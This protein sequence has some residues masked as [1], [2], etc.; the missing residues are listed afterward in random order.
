MLHGGEIYDKK[1]EL[2][3]SVSLNPLPCPVQVLDEI[4][5]AA[6]QVSN[7]PDIMQSEFVTAV[8]KAENRLSQKNAKFTAENIV[9]GNGAS[10]LLM[11]IVNMVRPKKALLPIPSFYGYE[12]ALGAAKDCATGHFLLREADGFVLNEDFIDA[13]TDDVDLVIL[14]NPNNPTGR[15]IP[16]SILVKTMD[17][18]RAVGATLIVD[19][20]FFRLSGKRDC[21]EIPQSA[22]NFTCEYPN[23]FV[24]DAYTK[25]FSIPGVRVGFAITSAENTGRLRRFLPEWNMSVFADRVGIKCAEI[26]GEGSF[27]KES[28]EMI[29]REKAYLVN[30]L[31]KIG[32]STCESDTNFILIRSDEELYNRLLEHK[33]LIRDCRTFDGLDI[34]YYRIAIKDHNANERLITAIK[35]L[36]NIRER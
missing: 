18:C 10:E 34:G 17:K 16:E 1:I 14:G 19:E 8:A 7:Y 15:L 2:D 35:T 23:L 20:C 28:L 33:I 25:L 24:V 12:H 5:T 30:E 26:T 31:E 9:G 3:F 11:A 21:E 32:I 29:Q 4:K 27:T 13:I 22:R 36:C 6:D